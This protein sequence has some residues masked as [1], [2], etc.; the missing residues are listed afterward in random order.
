[1]VWLSNWTLTLSLLCA[2]GLRD[3]AVVEQHTQTVSLLCATELKDT[4]VVEQQQ[5]GAEGV[6][7]FLCSSGCSY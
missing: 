2:T 4:A 7:R 6:C 3:T 5:D 1:M